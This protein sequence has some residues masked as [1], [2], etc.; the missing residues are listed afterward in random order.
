MT[1][2]SAKGL[3][4][5]NVFFVGL[6]EG[7]LPHSRSLLEPKELSE[8]IRLAYVG[9]TRARKRLFLVYAQYRMSFG[10]RQ[11]QMPSRV[12]KA[13]PKENVEFQ[14]PPLFDESQGEIVVEEMD[15]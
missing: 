7:I 4:F 10:N 9:L 5:D 2:H 11:M 14:G 12:L 6:E 13:L 3:E 15:F 8:E 1:L